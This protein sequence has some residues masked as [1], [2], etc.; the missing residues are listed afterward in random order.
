LVGPTGSGKTETF[1]CAV[2]YTFGPGHLT[3]FD[4]SE[5]QDASAVKKL[6]GAERDDRACWAARFSRNPTAPVIR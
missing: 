4:M 5:Y 1:T 6:I 3:I 2:N